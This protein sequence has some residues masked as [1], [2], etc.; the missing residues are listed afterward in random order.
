MVPTP[1]CSRIREEQENAKPKPSEFPVTDPIQNI[2]EETA[3]LKAT[4]MKARSA[5]DE[6]KAEQHFHAALA[7]ITQ[8][9]K[10]AGDCLP[11]SEFLELLQMNTELALLCGHAAQARL[12]ISQAQE[13][14]SSDAFSEDWS[15]FQKIDSWPDEWLVASVRGEPP[16]APALD[17]L[18]NRYWNTL[19]AR[20][21]LLTG[22]HSAAADL[23]QEAWCRILRSRH[24]LRPGGNFQAYLITIATNL[25]RDNMRSIY[26][27]GPM[28]DRHLAS[29]NEEHLNDGETVVLMDALPDSK[30]YDRHERTSLAMDIDAALAKLSP[31][32]RDVLVARYV[33][34]ESCLEIGKFYGRTEQTISGWIRTATRQLK[35]HLEDPHEIAVETEHLKMF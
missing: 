8:A 18:V 35:I 27:A 21:Q 14:N 31:L 20:C 10:N 25:W 34:G 9:T 30:A 5:G 24:R 22:N 12:L 6:S 32:L 2:L 4:G 3:T 15:Q 16:D 17:V 19:F 28:A 33:S 13:T 7:F 23:S 11:S 29:L 1:G 26:R